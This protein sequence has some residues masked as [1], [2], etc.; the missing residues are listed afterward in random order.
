MSE[1]VMRAAFTVM[2]V[3]L[4]GTSAM[5]VVLS[6]ILFVRSVTAEDVVSKETF[7]ALFVVGTFNA[8]AAVYIRHMAKARDA[9]ESS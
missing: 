9:A 1:P 2:F 7:W 6:T 4:V 5:A 3:N 8:F